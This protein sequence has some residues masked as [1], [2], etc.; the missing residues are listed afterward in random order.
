MNKCEQCG[1]NEV[2]VHLNRELDS[3]YLC[4]DCYNMIMG[5]ELEVDL[6]PLIDSFSAKDFQGKSRTF[7]VERRIAPEGICLEATENLEFGYKFAVHGELLSNQIELLNKLI[8]KTRKGIS[9]QQ[10]ES[11]VFPNG[12]EYHTMIHDHFTGL[13]DY[14]ENFNES[15]LVIIDGKSFTWEEVGKMV[16]AYEGFQIRLKIYDATDDLE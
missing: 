15:P 14:D 7:F 2:K 12:L 4:I 3:I 16:M 5:E 10:I 11:D 6:E 1:T 9:V 8:A 13:I